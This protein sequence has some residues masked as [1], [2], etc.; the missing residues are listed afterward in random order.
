M[1]EGTGLGWGD[2]VYANK[3]IA[4]IDLDDDSYDDTPIVKEGEMGRVIYAVDY[5]T[6]VTFFSPDKII[7]CDHKWLNH[8]LPHTIDQEYPCYV[9][10]TYNGLE[11]AKLGCKS[12]G[13]PYDPI[14]GDILDNSEANTD[15]PDYTYFAEDMKPPTDETLY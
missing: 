10:G 5:V 6:V 3:D 12:C 2:I 9:C 8:E 7:H 1:V 13:V 4:P 15:E 14:S 11:E